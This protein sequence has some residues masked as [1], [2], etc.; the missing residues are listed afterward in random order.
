MVLHVQAREAELA[1]AERANATF[2]ERARQVINTDAKPLSSRSTTGE[3]NTHGRGVPQ[4]PELP[5]VVTLTTRPQRQAGGA[6]G[7]GGESGGAGGADAGSGGGREGGGHPP[8]V[9]RRGG[10]KRAAAA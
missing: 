6:R 8:G 10:G 7:E 9:P 1:E 5:I 3:F 4:G 2:A